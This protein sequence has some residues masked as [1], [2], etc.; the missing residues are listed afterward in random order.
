M[1]G[2]TEDGP[3]HGE[4]RALP[5]VSTLYSCARSPS[6]LLEDV[7]EANFNAL[8][9]WPVKAMLSVPPHVCHTVSSLGHAW[10]S[11]APCGNHARLAP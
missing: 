4:H 5:R 11:A 10:R 8:Y 6:H 7:G 3:V 2:E 9:V 1:G